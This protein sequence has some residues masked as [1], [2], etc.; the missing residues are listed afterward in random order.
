M[1][2]IPFALS[3]SHLVSSAGADV[4]FAA[5]V[6]LA[7]L[8]LLFFSQARETAM[9]RRRAD[10][11][12]EQLHQLAAYVDQLARRP[13]AQPANAPAVAP[14]PAAARAAGRPAP[15]VAAAAAPAASRA[16]P[17]PAPA[18]AGAMA[19]IPVAPAGVAAPALSSAT[20]LVPLGAA[21][22]IS[23]RSLKNGHV[24]SEPVPAAEPEPTGPPPST[25]AG[26]ANGVARAPVVAAPMPATTGATSPVAATTGAATAVAAPPPAGG[27]RALPRRGGDGDGDSGPGGRAPGSPPG[28]P[29]APPTF[30]DP[31]PPG[32]R[33]LTRFGMMAVAVVVVVVIVALVVI[34]GGGGGGTAAH[35]NASSARSATAGASRRT[36]HAS[37][38]RV[39]PSK[40]TVAVLNGT[41]TYHLAADV[42][43]KLTGAGYR[44]G[45][46][47]NAPTQTLTT[48]TVGYTQPS[49]RADALAVAKSLN[50]GSASVQ[51]VAQSDRTAACGGGATCPAEVVVTVG[52]DL[53]SLASG[54][55]AG[56]STGA[57][58]G[59]ATAASTG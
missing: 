30:R 35:S 16:V 46:A 54:S 27:E 4:G 28:R 7:I 59:T 55:S 19:T 15:A 37:A 12:E 48:T 43:S 53:A 36:R 6:G 49:Y 10:E 58:T 20:R 9:L 51:G 25:A 21:D 22:E 17:T 23:I 31:V 40:V 1:A 57:A 41:S 42:M 34:V 24:D 11:A 44:K 45:T 18:A 5:I 8:V 32:R 26:G 3:V 2:T 33:R 39:V 47:A 50:L 38:T 14:A 29:A 56:T 13:A 52:S